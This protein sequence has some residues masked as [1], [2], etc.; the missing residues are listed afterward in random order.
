MSAAER[1]RHIVGCCLSNLLY[2]FAFARRATIISPLSHNKL[3]H[4]LEYCLVLTGQWMA[5]DS[6]PN[7]SHIEQ[8]NSWKCAA[9]IADSA[10]MC[11]HSV[12]CVQDWLVKKLAWHLAT[13][14]F[15]GSYKGKSKVK[16]K[17]PILV[18]EHRGPELILDSRQSATQ[19]VG[20][21]PMA[22]CH[23][24]PPGPQRHTHA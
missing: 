3:V 14:V 19:P 5:V 2:L 6:R 8:V 9:R 18:I 23:H 21:Y 7:L 1:V 12:F 16:V 4:I 17:G 20:S 13:V 10:Q 11:L 15:G 24:L 22:G